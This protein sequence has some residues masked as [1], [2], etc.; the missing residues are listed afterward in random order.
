MKIINKSQIRALQISP[1][2]CVEWVKESFALKK[3]SQLPPK[4]SVHPS[5]VD[6]YTAMPCLL[7]ETYNRY[8]LKLV[9]RLQNATPAL[10]SNIQVYDAKSGDL[11]ALMDCD[12]IT[13]MRTGAVA[14]LAAQ[15]FRKKGDIT[16]SFVGLGNV[17]MATMLCLLETEPEINHNVLL[18]RFMNEAE[19]FI[20]R[21]K[22]YKNVTF[23]V[24]DDIHKMFSQSDVIYSCITQADELLCEDDKC[25]KPGV[26]LIPIHT[27][28]FQNCDLTFDKIYGDDKG[29]VQGFKYFNQ[30]KFFAEIQDV[31]EG[32]ADGR[33]NDQERIISYNVGLGIH[34][35]IFA[36][37]IYDMINKTTEVKIEKETERFWI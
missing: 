1:A 10:C 33:K 23:S 34:D 24:I 28:G 3:L 16:Y 35:A 30:Y 27:R 14:V 6:F 22:E 12:W 37:K 29:H 2:T 15:I 20:D 32:K 9:S 13:A 11:L 31:I 26:T 18:Y 21:F 5:G 4:I 19:L 36:S 17:A 25:F 7:P 8:C